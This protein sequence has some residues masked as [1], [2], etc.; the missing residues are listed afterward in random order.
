MRDLRAFVAGMVVAVV[1]GMA[2]VTAGQLPQ[3]GVSPARFFVQN[4]TRAEAVPVTLVAVDREQ[5]APV[6][7]VQAERLPPVDLTGATVLD[8]ARAVRAR[9]FWD[10]REL[11][12]VT[13]ADRQQAL[14]NA[15]AEGWEAVSMVTEPDGRL[16]VLMKRPR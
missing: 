3:P 4:R 12:G 9:Q 7:T 14:I 5:P 13:A 11:T 2:A 10:Y 16:R 6:L 8:I 15:G 1:I